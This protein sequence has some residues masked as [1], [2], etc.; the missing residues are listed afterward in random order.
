MVLFKP[1][2]HLAGL[3]SNYRVV[4]GC[5]IGRAVEQVGSNAALLQKFVMPVESMLHDVGEKLFTAAT[6]PK[7]RTAEDGFQFSENLRFL[8]VPYG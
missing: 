3:H 4:A 6:A 1:P 8:H 7:R 2:A 5:V